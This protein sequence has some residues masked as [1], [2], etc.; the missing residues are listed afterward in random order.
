M[1]AMKLWTIGLAVG[2]LACGKGSNGKDTKPDPTTWDTSGGTPSGT[3]TITVP[4]TTHTNLLIVSIDTLRKDHISRYDPL[5]RDLMPFVDSLMD[6]GIV[7]DAHHPGSN[8]TYHSMST[9]QSGK[10]PLDAG[11]LPRVAPNDW[12]GWPAGSRFMADDL[13]DAGFT[14]IMA[15]ANGW[16]KPDFGMGGSFDQYLGEAFDLADVTYSLGSGA[17]QDQMNLGGVD[18][19]YLHLHFLEP[20]APYTPPV[21][22]RI[23]E[24]Q[25]APLPWNIDNQPDHY[26][27]VNDWSNLTPGEQDLLEAHMRVR[28]EGEL[29]WLDDRIEAFWTYL[30]TKGLLDDT[31]VVFYSDHGEQFWEQGNQSH[32][33]NMY[34]E[35]TSGLFFLW[36][37]DM[38]ADTM[39][40]RTSGIDIAPTIF[41]HLGLDAP[42]DWQGLP[43]SEIPPDRPVYADANARLGPIHSVTRNNR[44]LVYRWNGEAYFYHLEVDPF[45]RDDQFNAANPEVQEMWELLRP[46]IQAAM[47][48]APL[49]TP[50]PPLGLA[51]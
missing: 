27:A 37:K 39:V 33:F 29:R 32:A 50:I 42:A 45:M 34:T 51:I 26:A 38:A 4:A 43:I 17:L 21:E 31:L 41:R 16:L 8:W 14:T 23:G 15:S 2:L 9:A 12:G 40:L 46:R 6:E 18:R 36:S 48:L 11:I 20:H 5:N 1:R 47:P 30:D 13:N 35:E 44:H 24:D 7:A 49:Q 3:T 10:Y 19:W 25:L 22:Y 28:Y